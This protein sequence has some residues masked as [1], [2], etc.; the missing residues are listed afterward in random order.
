VARPSKAEPTKAAVTLVV[1]TGTQISGPTA[2]PRKRNDSTAE[3]APPRFSGTMTAAIR[4]R[5][6]VTNENSEPARIQ[7]PVTAA[8][9]LIGPIR[10]T[11]SPATSVAT[12]PHR[13]GP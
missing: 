3:S 11:T 6:T 10:A 5:T 8:V 1:R 13:R 12:V 9:A 4:C 2:K 7:S